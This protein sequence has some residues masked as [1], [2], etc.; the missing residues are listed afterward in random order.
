MTKV[1]MQ[2]NSCR[3]KIKTLDELEKIVNQLKAQGK[4]IVHCHGVFDL[5]HPGHVRHLEA[6]KEAGDVLIVTITQDEY[7]DKGPG[8]PVFNQHLRAETLAAMQ[9]VDYVAVNQW[10]TAVKTIQKLKPH[11]YAKGSEYAAPENDLTGGIVHEEDAVKA[12]G[13]R[14]IFTDEITFS[15]TELINRHL[16][17]FTDEAK[18]FLDDFKKQHPAS[19][20]VALLKRLTNLKV[21]VIGETIIDEY[22]YCKAI[23]KPVKE[24]VLSTKY[25]SE[26]T[27]AGGV[28]A[29]ANHLA[30][31]CNNVHMVSCLGTL[32]TREEYI[33]D[34]LKPHI[35]PKFFYRCNTHTIV[36]RRFV[37]PDFL[38]KMFQ[39]VYI[40]DREPPTELNKE[41][42]AYLET[43]IPDYDVVLV[44]DYGHG[45]IGKDVVRIL[46][47]KA[48]FLSVNAQTNSS[49]YGFNPITKYPRADY[50]CIDEQEM[51]LASHDRF[52][53]LEDIIIN[54][55]QKLNCRNVVTTRGHL[56]SIAYDTNSA[57]HEI[58]VFSNKVVDR[59]G[60]GDAYLAI[61]SPCV[62]L[63][64]NMEVV[65]FIGNAV[66]A[67]AV[68]IVCNRSSIEPVSLYKYITT[69]L[70]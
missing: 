68:G 38:T 22:H 4:T 51:R 64:A 23:G 49:N 27:F 58:P 55:S 7:V 59:I 56:G 33:V 47:E 31:F 9:P 30:G 53:R 37:D 12:V 28:A 1:N 34:H 65:G 19:E 2:Q 36:K 42:C 43:A 54:I 11:V 66:G 20:I 18:A 16:T 6:A 45:F 21:M 8:R 67:M 39:L 13:G 57:F 60:A 44:V 29:V 17:V 25:I 62:A 26:E 41:I 48:K 5:M 46:C 63:G 52:G 69:L 10:P 14:I 15:S 24:A 40:D 32:D 61:T 35:Q 70:K 3:Q 50:I